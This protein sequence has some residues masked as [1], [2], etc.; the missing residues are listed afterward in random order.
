VVSAAAE[1]EPVDGVTRGGGDMGAGDTGGGDT[2]GGGADGDGVAMPGAG[3]AIQAG[4][5]PE[6]DI[7]DSI[8]RFT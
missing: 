7:P 4:G 1:D 8:S 3:V 6:S 2:G 5:A